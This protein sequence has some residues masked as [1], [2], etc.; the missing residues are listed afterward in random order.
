MGIPE[1]G[2]PVCEKLLSEIRPTKFSQIVK[3]SGLSHGTGVWMDNNRDLFLGKT[4]H[5]KIGL[6]EMICCRDDI[7]TSLIRYGLNRQDAFKISE[8]VRK[9]NA[10]KKP[11]DWTE[12]VKLMTSHQVPQWFIE[13]AGKILYLFPK[14]HATAYVVFAIRTAYFKV[15]HPLV[16]FSAYFS[17]RASL[18]DY[19]A[20]SSNDIGALKAKVEFY[21]GESRTKNNKAN[22]LKL[23]KLCEMT[24]EAL[25]MGVKFLGVDINKSDATKYV[26]EE[27]KLRL[28]LCSI[29]GLGNNVGEKIMAAREE[30][31]FSSIE[32]LINR[33]SVSKTVINKLRNYGSLGDLQDNEP[34]APAF[35]LFNF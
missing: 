15:Y 28:P 14:A 22:D 35:N 6:D 17:T 21:N 19:D 9:G 18:Y 24:I 10:I 25:E 32:D 8:F 11:K 3:V 23:M 30:Q 7:N 1:F 27:D 16:F 33:T 34:E 4:D 2:T 20:F 31:P 13:S 26:I 12:M 29:D 5:G